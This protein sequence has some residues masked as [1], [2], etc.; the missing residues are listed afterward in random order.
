MTLLELIVAIGILV[1]LASA[2]LPLV[3]VTI[4]R[5]REAELHRDLREIRNAIGRPLVVTVQDGTSS[6]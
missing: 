3:H 4:Q 5:N 6:N 1:I 2:A